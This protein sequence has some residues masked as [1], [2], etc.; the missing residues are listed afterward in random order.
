MF[1]GVYERKTNEDASFEVDGMSVVKKN[2]IGDCKKTV[3]R[4]EQIDKQEEK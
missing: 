4:E 2:D 3:N 1:C